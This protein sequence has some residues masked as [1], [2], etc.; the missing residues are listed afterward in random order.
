MTRSGRAFVLGFVSLTALV[1]TSAEVQAFGLDDVAARAAKLADAPYQK[2]GSGLPKTVKALNYDQFRDIRFRPDRALWRNAKLPFEVMFFHRGWFYED[3][4]VIREVT[5]DGEREIPF[6]PDAFDYGKNKID[7]EELK[8]A[9]FAG[10]R[11]HFPLNSATYKDETLVFL[12]ASYLRALGRGQVYGLSAR[13]LAIDT[14][15]NT[16]EEFPRFVEFWIERPAPNANELKIYAL[17]DSPRAAG[18]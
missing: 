12:G 16:G 3:P 4:V 8:G 17:L 14:A 9:G 1:S 15:E 2:P 13:G 10:F 5:A 18:A 7:R 11:V 6:D